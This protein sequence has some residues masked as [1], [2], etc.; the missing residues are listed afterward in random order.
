VYPVTEFG[1]HMHTHLVQNNKSMKFVLSI[2]FYMVQIKTLD[3]KL[4]RM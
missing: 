2:T 3:F 1:V 4:I